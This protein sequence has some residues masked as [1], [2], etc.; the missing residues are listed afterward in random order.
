MRQSRHQRRQGMTERKKALIT[1]ATS[2][3]GLAFAERFA[4]R[5][6]D[7][8]VTGRRAKII[9]AAAGDIARRH[10]VSVTVILAELSDE[11]GVRKVLNAIRKADRLD[12]LVNN[13]GF[14]LD[15]IFHKDTIERHV[16]MIDVHVTA[17]VRFVHA[18]LPG[19]LARGQGTIINVS[20]LGA[21]IPGPFNAIYGGTKAFLNI[22]SESVAIEL[23]HRGIRMQS[24]CP[25]FTSTD[26]HMQM[27]IEEDIKKK[28]KRWMRPE[29]VVDR[30][31]KDLSR[32]KV[33]CIPTFRGRMLRNF[34]DA[35]PRKLYYRIFRKIY[36]E[37]LD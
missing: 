29:D 20:S 13:A 30:S 4:G 10:G 35:L 16:M 23:G 6:Y 2:G 1:G 31:L 21:F 28:V 27:G 26:F 8:I 12:V 19:M 17:A 25:G 5:G 34:L 14:G 32:G 7:L 18:A 9:Q 24:L 22:F 33:I 15:K 3:I 11:K 36:R 37:Y